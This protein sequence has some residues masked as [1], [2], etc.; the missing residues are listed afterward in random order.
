MRRPADNPVVVRRPTRRPAFSRGHRCVAAGG[1]ACHRRRQVPADLTAGFR[2]DG[3]T[4]EEYPAFAGT[5]LA[6]ELIATSS[7][8]GGRASVDVKGPVSPRSFGAIGAWDGH[9]VSRG[10]VVVDATWHHF[11]NINLTGDPFSTDPAK[12]VGFLASPQGLAAY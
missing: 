10:R 1:Y 4:I 2:F 7:I 3:Y 5:R 6:P 8:V 12:Q 9:R 11:F